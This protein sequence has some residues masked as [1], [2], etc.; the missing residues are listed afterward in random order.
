MNTN[1]AA[2]T[3]PGWPQ[4]LHDANENYSFSRLRT[5][6]RYFIRDHPTLLDDWKQVCDLSASV[7]AAIVQVL[8]KKTIRAG[9]REDVRCVTASRGVTCKS[10]LRNE[11]KRAGKRNGFTLRIAK[12]N[13]C[14]DNAVM[15]GI[16]AL[17]KPL[18]DAPLP[19]LDEEIKPGWV[20]A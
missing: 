9:K 17:R 7:Q 8:V 19:P 12:E 20:L 14:T 5:S 10:G 18:T 2:F 16:L 3:S 1:R 6:V 4:L 13:L 15:V 11:L